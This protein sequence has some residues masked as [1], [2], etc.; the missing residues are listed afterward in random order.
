MTRRL[1]REAYEHAVYEIDRLWQF[2][3]LDERLPASGPTFGPPIA[4][5]RLSH[6]AAT[7]M[8][9]RNSIFKEPDMK[10]LFS[11]LSAT[12]LLL[13]AAAAIAAEPAIPPRESPLAVRPADGSG[14]LEGTYKITASEKNG[15]PTPAEKIDGVI[16]VFTSDKIVAT[17][18]D[19]KE[20]YSATYKIDA[21]QL[22]AVISMVSTMPE[23][24]G[25][26]AKGLIEVGKDKVR[27]IYTLPDG[28][29]MPTEFKTVDGQVMV[30]L[31][32]FQPL[33]KA[34]E[35]KVPELK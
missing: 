32:R 19:K 27:L 17:D 1:K 30:T 15:E 13:F 6:F 2:N 28:K 3:D 12:M 18:R 26:T 20:V 22:P 8:H 33:A 35:E 34:I 16:V 21:T 11:T 31:E 23:A 5:T 25:V 7:S 9:S 10:T 14:K 29:I 4:L 24:K